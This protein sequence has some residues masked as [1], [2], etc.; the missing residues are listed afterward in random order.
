[1]NHYH[2]WLQNLSLSMRIPSIFFTIRSTKVLQ[3]SL[4]YN[5]KSEVYEIL[6]SSKS[7]FIPMI[8]DT[9]HMAMVVIQDRSSGIL[10]IYLPYYPALERMRP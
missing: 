9:N 3:N 8:L 6:P 7:Q 10:V 2:M 4:L 1:M 5:K